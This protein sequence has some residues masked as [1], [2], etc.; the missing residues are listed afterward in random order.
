MSATYVQTCIEN[1]SK[2]TDKRPGKKRFGQEKT[3]PGLIVKGKCKGD[4]MRIVITQSFSSVIY[5]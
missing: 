5:H 2:E 1:F 4:A 3:V